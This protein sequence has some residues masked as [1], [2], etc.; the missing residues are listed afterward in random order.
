MR[1]DLRD[2]GLYDYEIDQR[3][4]CELAILLGPTAGARVLSTGPTGAAELQVVPTG[5][6]GTAE[7]VNFPAGHSGGPGPTTAHRSTAD[8][9]GLAIS[10]ARAA[11]GG[12]DDASEERPP[13]DSNN[14]KRKQKNKRSVAQDREDASSK[15][16]ADPTDDCVH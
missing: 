6:T 14:P 5:P 9:A 13:D 3:T 10:P 2:L 4:R 8:P 11:N 15:T 1:Q 7:I 12:N 16:E